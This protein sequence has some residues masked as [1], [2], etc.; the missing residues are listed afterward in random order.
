MKILLPFIIIFFYSCGAQRQNK[1]SALESLQNLFGI[2]SQNSVSIGEATDFHSSTPP[3]PSDVVIGSN[4]GEAPLSPTALDLSFVSSPGSTSPG[5]SILKIFIDN[6]NYTNAEHFS[7]AEKEIGVTETKN[8]VIKNTG[9]ATLQIISV[10]VTS[11]SNQFRFKNS[12]M[13]AGGFVSITPNSSINFQVEFQPGSNGKKLGTLVVLSN[14]PNLPEKRLVLNGIGKDEASAVVMKQSSFVSRQDTILIE[15]SHSM[16]IASICPNSEPNNQ[17][18]GT[19]PYGQSLIR[20]TRNLSDPNTDISGFCYWNS[21]RQL[22][23]DPIETLSPNTRYYIDL[24]GARKFGSAQGLSCVRRIDEAGCNL[25]S[26]SFVTEPS[27]QISVQIAPNQFLHPAPSGK[28]A[29]LEETQIPQVNITSAISDFWE[30]DEIRLKKLNSPPT[31]ASIPWSSEINLTTLA[32]SSLRPSRGA[33]T[34][35]FEIRKGAKKYFRVFGFHYGRIASDPNQPVESTARVNIGTGANGLGRIG[36]LLERLFRSDGN[37]GSASDNFRIGGKVFS[38][39]YNDILGT[40]AN[41]CSRIRVSSTTGIRAGMVLR[42]VSLQPNTFIT[43]IHSS[44]FLNTGD[45]CPNNST[46]TN[47]PLL[48][49]SRAATN[50][51]G[52]SGSD[53]K[54]SLGPDIGKFA[55]LTNGNSSITFAQNDD[56]YP[57]VYVNHPNLPEGTTIGNLISGTSWTLSNASSASLSNTTVTIGRTFIQNPKRTGNVLTGTDALGQNC[58]SN[59]NDFGSAREL[60]HLLSIGPFC[61]INWSWGGFIANGR[62]DVYVTTMTIEN[63]ANGTPNDNLLVTLNPVAGAS[64]NGQLN[65][66]LNGKRLKGTLRLFMHSGGGL[67]GGLANGAVY[68]VDFMMNPNGGCSSSSAFL[69][70][71]TTANFQ[72]ATAMTSLNI[73]NSNGMVSLNV[74]NPN[75]WRDNP[76]ATEFNISGWNSAICAYNVRTIKPGTFDSIIQAVLESVIPGIQWRVVQGVIRDTIQTVTPNILNAIFVQMR[77]DQRND[78]ID[79]NLPD[80]LPAPFDRTKIN[81]GINLAQTAS[82][83]VHSDGLDL[84]AAVSALACQKNSPSD[85]NCIDRNSI[86]EKPNS[87]HT[88]TGFS[89]G[90]VR[91]SD[92]TAPRSQMARSAVNSNMGTGRIST[93]D[94]SGVLLSLHSDS[95]NQ[96]FYQMWWNGILNLKLDQNFANKIKGFRGDEDRLFQIFQILL[97]ADSILKVLAPGRTKIQFRDS[98]NNLRTI[99]SNDD[100]FFR[101]EPLLPPHIQFSNTNLSKTTNGLKQP[102]LD[103]QWTDLLLKIYGKQGNEEYLLSTVKIGISTKLLFGAKEFTSGVGCS[104]LNPSFCNGTENDF[105]KVSALQLNLCDDNNAEDLENS[106]RSAANRRIDCDEARVGFLDGNTENDLD[107]F[108]TMEVLESNLDN[109]S[110]LNPNGIKE[111]LDPTIQKL[112][113]PVL[114]YVLE[115]IPLERKSKNLQVDSTYTSPNFSY[116]IGRKEDPNANGNKIAANCGLRMNQLS[117]LPYS[118]TYLN[119]STTTQETSPYILLNVKLSDYTFWGNCSL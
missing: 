13:Y 109:P 59:P 60:N 114:N 20:I 104:G 85:T 36:R 118:S 5:S 32:D 27:F 96:L 1:D 112:I 108:Y 110:G 14:D 116:E 33:N 17:F 57:G 68:D 79:V 103:L 72:L 25:N 21:F 86:I 69:N 19:N 73:P 7:F 35:F 89:N 117:S 53:I 63:I 37:F 74:I 4:T 91:V 97:K 77:K 41:G 115:F 40:T 30:A 56:I 76:S 26:T 12:G 98:S 50:S 66:N 3:N 94:G 58:L 106:N 81:L 61:R 64:S 119:Q 105:Y 78:G 29:I 38:D 113:I 52:Q 10:E 24:S 22:V 87:P 23:V 16:D 44:G 31:N 15:F 75:S 82:N 100:V 95:I 47:G 70:Y 39:S 8:V 107:L 93:S 67:A 18:P 83:R 34:Y 71:S 45:G 46:F 111:V 80:Y 88:G 2:G 9:T 28:S 92:G 51:F 62:S 43:S 54:I 11:I 101:L 55:N 90:F 48:I 49:I 84:T 102:L 42:G 6:E 99:Q 65:L